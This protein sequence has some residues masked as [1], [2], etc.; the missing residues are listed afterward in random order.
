MG[1]CDF[2]VSLRVRGRDRIKKDLGVQDWWVLR[3]DRL[4][5]GRDG[6]AV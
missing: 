5:T 1:Q 2:T 6:T 3:T 4:L